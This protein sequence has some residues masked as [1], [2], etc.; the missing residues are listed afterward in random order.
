MNERD[1]P[2]NF[3][4]TKWLHGYKVG[5]HVSFGFNGDYDAGLVIRV[6]DASVWVQRTD[7]DLSGVKDEDKYLGRVYH[8]GDPDVRWVDPG[9]ALAHT[10]TAILRFRVSR[11]R[12][13]RGALVCDN[14]YTLHHGACE[15]RNPHI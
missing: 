6:T 8:E 13:R 10:D 3:G 11:A 4:E 7:L 14:Y 1:L 5:D 15:G 12:G 9:Q 2:R